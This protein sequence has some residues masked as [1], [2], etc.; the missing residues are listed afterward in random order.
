MPTLTPHNPVDLIRTAFP[1]AIRD[2]VDAFGET[3]LII[4]SAHIAEVARFCRDTEGLEFNFLSDLCAVDYYPQEPRFAVCYHLYSIFFNRRVR[5]K[6]YLSSDDPHVPSVTE[7]WPSANWQEREAFDLM[8][9][10]FAGHPDLR[11][12]LLPR[13]WVGHPLRKDYPL[14][15][16]PVQ[17]TFNYDEI[18]RQKPLARE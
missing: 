4:E 17:F 7:L 14:G 16:E 5:L 6:V 10:V 18:R 11:R 2:V 9:I 1:E 3:T 12:V 13:D 15:Y 8:G